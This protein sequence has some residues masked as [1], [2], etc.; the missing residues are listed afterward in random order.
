MHGEAGDDLANALSVVNQLGVLKPEIV[1]LAMDLRNAWLGLSLQ[2]G[3]NVSDC[4][5]AVPDPYTAAIFV[6]S[7]GTNVAVDARF[8][9]NKLAAG[10]VSTAAAYAGA[11]AV[12]IV[13]P[14]SAQPRAVARIGDT[15]VELR[16]VEAK[17]H[18]AAAKSLGDALRTFSEAFTQPLDALVELAN[19]DTVTE[20]F[21]RDM[22]LD[23]NLL[24]LFGL[25][26][27]LPGA[28][29]ASKKLRFATRLVEEG[30]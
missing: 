29:R 8:M 21:V 6:A 5:A 30:R 14:E 28:V 26:D 1:A 23:P 7:L 25:L 12:I 13:E 16:K 10:W 3:S 19:V 24:E 27:R 11:N 2:W 15:L 9:F 4:V 17:P 18:R 20:R 22:G